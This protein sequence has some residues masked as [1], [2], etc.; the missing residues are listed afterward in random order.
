MKMQSLYIHDRPGRAVGRAA[1][2]PIGRGEPL[3]DH[4]DKYLVQKQ[5]S[6]SA[7]TSATSSV[8]G[9]RG[10]QRRKG[11]RRFPRR[12]VRDALMAILEEEDPEEVGED[13]EFLQMAL[14]DT[15]GDESVDE[16]EEDAMTSF[17]PPT[18]AAAIAG[19][20]SVCVTS[21]A[22][23][24]PGGGT[25][26][27]QSPAMMEIYAQ[28]YKARQRVREIK[29]MRQYF[30]K[31]QGKGQRQRDPAAQRWIEEQ[32]KTEP[33]F[34]C[35]KLGH[36]SQECPFRQQKGAT[37]ATNVTFPLGPTNGS[38]WDLL[39][40]MSGEGSVHAAVPTSSTVFIHV[41]PHCQFD[42]SAK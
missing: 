13:A 22:Q 21:P 12:K 24:G 33:C 5:G 42:P 16:D 35:H 4:E 26:D 7:S 20:Q 37:H 36:W 1:W 30:Q 34:I 19:E 38:E 25:G 18:A 31:G 14:A 2:L 32:Q 40:T 8:E 10:F 17:A 3:L 41:H 6:S 28:E 23:G 9:G 27:S 11:F 15:V 39:Q 29:K